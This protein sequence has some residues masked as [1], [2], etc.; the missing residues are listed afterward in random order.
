MPC[1]S[2]IKELMDEKLVSMEKL[3]QMTGIQMFTLRQYM[4]DQMCMTLKTAKKISH[5]LDVKIEDLYDWK[6]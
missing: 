4:D 2:R 5:V 6:G 1:H 3:S